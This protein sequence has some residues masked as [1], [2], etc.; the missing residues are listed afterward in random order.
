M[1]SRAMC[2]RAIDA[3]EAAAEEEEE[4]EAAGNDTGAGDGGGAGVGAAGAAGVSSSC[5][6]AREGAADM[7]EEVLPDAGGRE[8]NPTSAPR[9]SP[10]L[11]RCTFAQRVEAT[12]SRCP[13]AIRRG[14]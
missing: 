5:A 2:W 14:R 13:P 6:G 7:A 9:L 1:C 3:A 10:R 4:E 11:P 12:G 8:E